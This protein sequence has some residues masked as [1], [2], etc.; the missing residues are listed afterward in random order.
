MIRSYRHCKWCRH[1]VVPRVNVLEQPRVGVEQMVWEVEKHFSHSDKT[2][3]FNLPSDKHES[4]YQ[5]IYFHQ[6]V[7]HYLEK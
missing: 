7:A 6:H 3:Q 4:E 5:D 2:Q 1:R